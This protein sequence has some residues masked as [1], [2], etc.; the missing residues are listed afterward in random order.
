MARI[1]L[2][3]GFVVGYGYIMEAFMAWY[4]G[5]EFHIYM[6]A[7]RMLG[8]YAWAFWTMLACNILVIQ[9]LWWRR[10]RLNHVALFVI[11]I[12][13]NV[14]MWLERYV[15]VITSAHRDFLPSMWETPR[16]T[17]WDWMFLAGS[18]GLFFALMFLFVR[19]LP[20]IS[21]FEVRELVHERQHDED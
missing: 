1:M 10:V 2:A 15:I 13:V 3:T 8:P 6:M 5:D 18:I 16:P 7:N 19:L 11:A 12:L 14:G 21:T 4:A 17:W 9:P 20:A